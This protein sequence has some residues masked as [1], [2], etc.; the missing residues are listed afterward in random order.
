[1]LVLTLDGQRYSYSTLC[2]ISPYQSIVWCHLFF[3]LLKVWLIPTLVVHLSNTYFHNLLFNLFYRSFN[4]SILSKAS[5]SEE[6]FL[7]VNSGGP[8]HPPTNSVQLFYLPHREE[9]LIEREGWEQVSRWLL[10]DGRGGGGDGAIVTRNGGINN[11]AVL[12]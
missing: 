7:H 11:L 12:L 3:F 5:C 8:P 6:M 4:H 1:M 2:I 10:T 9:R